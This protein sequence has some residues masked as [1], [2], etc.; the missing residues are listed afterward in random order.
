MTIVDF[1]ESVLDVKLNDYEKDF[2]VKMD[3]AI[4]NN[5][6]ILPRQRPVR[7]WEMDLIYA[8]TY[9]KSMRNVLN[10]K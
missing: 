8:M 6:F 3:I 7:E 10:D 4:K 2:V 9:Y 1:I 5:A